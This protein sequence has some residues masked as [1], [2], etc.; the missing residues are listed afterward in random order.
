[1]NPVV[2]LFLELVLVDEAVD[3]KCAEEVTD[4]LADAASAFLL[5]RL[6]SGQVPVISVAYN[7][8]QMA[9]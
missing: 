7:F 5:P 9:C 4:A 8:L 3:L 1:V 6:M 2:D